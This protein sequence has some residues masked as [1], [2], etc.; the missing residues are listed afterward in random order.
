MLF[1]SP[2]DL[3]QLVKTA[4]FTGTRFGELARLQVKHVNIESG[5]IYITPEAKSNKG[6]H[7][8]LHLDAI[9]YFKKL[10]AGKTGEDLVLVK[11]DGKFWRKNHQVRPLLEACKAAKIEPSISFHKGLVGKLK[12]AKKNKKPATTHQ[13]IAELTENRISGSLFCRQFA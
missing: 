13:E 1:R 7:V 9:D 10:M 2:L 5:M 11:Y 4:L 6:R 8:P 12:R 3:R